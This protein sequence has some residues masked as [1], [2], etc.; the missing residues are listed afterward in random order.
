[1]LYLKRNFKPQWEFLKYEIRK[2]SIAFSKEKSKENREKIARL[3]GK[4]KELEQNLNWDE[5]LEQYGIY[6]SELN[7]ICNDVSNGIKI[8]SRYNWYEFCEKS[9]KFFLNLEENCAEQSIVIK[10]FLTNKK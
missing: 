5:N 2:F 4:L 10:S 7:D 8:R 6:K 3:E 9:N 1:M